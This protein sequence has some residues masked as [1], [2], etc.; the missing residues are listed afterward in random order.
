MKF[1]HVHY[2]IIRPEWKVLHVGGGKQPFRRANFIIDT[3]SW[4]DRNQKNSWVQSIP[5]YFT[6]QT[7]ITQ[8][9]ENTPW[10]FEDEEF[11]YVL[12]DDALVSTRDPIAVCRE[13]ERVGKRGYIEVPSVFVNHLRGAEDSNLT[14]YVSHRWIAT[15][16]SD[17]IKFSIKHPS[18]HTKKDFWV[19]NPYKSI[20]PWFAP[21]YSVEG[22]FWNDSIECSEDL[23]TA[24]FPDWFF[25]ENIW[26]CKIGYNKFNDLWKIDDFLTVMLEET[27]FSQPG[28]IVRLNSLK[29]KFSIPL[30]TDKNQRHPEMLKFEHY[31][32]KNIKNK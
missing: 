9:L 3:C 18:I 5:E 11:D 8:P 22:L 23:E 4:Y 6:K 1:I 10:P 19:A 28:K 15:T 13:M 25:E 32:A 14:G 26:K 29:S 31:I 7:W 17:D 16:I 20:S 12:I 27:P 30:V 24:E 21:K 2:D